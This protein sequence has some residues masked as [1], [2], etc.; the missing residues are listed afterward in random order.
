M[1]WA[2]LVGFVVAVTPLVLTPGASFT[3]ATQRSLAGDRHAAGWVVAGTATGIWCHALLAAVGLSAVVLHSAQ[4]FTAVRIAGAAYLIGL[5]V[6]T[7]ARTRHHTPRDPSP[8]AAR[9]LPW[10][11]HHAYPQ[12]V[13]AN[14]LNPKAASVYLT[15]APQFLSAHR[16]GVVPMLTLA[17]AHI[18]VMAAWLTIWSLVVVRGRTLTRSPR[19]TSVQRL[20]GAVLIGLGL[21][22]AATR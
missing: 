4:A 21:R 13:L 9:R 12:A 19:T 6:L 16:I 11:G 15:L 7:L 22:T 10:T 8:A 18:A 17:T 20:G 3:L 1:T 14:V 2:A 5:G